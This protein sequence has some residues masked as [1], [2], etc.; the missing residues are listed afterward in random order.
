MKR[1]FISSAINLNEEKI[2]ILGW[3]HGLRDMKKIQFLVVRDHTGIVQ[4]THY[5]PNNNELAE[6]ISGVTKESAIEIIGVVKKNTGVNLHG[7]EIIP[8]KIIIHNLADPQLPINEESPQDLRLDWRFL[9]LRRPKNQLIFKAQT[10]AEEAMRE[11]WINEGLIEM[12]SP[13]LLSTASESGAELFQLEYFDKTACLA[14]SPQ[15]YKQMAMASGFN[16]VFEIGPVFRANKSRTRRHDTEFTSVDVEIPWINSYEDIMSFMER[17]L[18]HVLERINDTLGEE[19]KKLFEV[20]VNVPDSPF[21]RMTMQEAYTL[22]DELGHSTHREEKG[23]LDP[24]GEQILC[25]YMQRKTGHEFLFV[26]EYP[27][28]VRP[29]YHMRYEDRPK[30]TKSFDLLWK[31]IEVTTGAQREHR[32][33]TLLSQALEKGLT[34]ESITDY[35]NIFR[36]GCPPHGGFGFGLTRMLMMLLNLENVR[37]ATYL[38]RG[39][40]RLTP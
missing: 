6:A 7:V 26:T 37:E 20:N 31:G 27:T 36:F 10:V 25:E 17:W 24:K 12:H 21:P 15:F 40:N 14:Q 2:R 3:V 22:L 29:F 4:I 8:E 23:D 19:I 13:K 16:G 30:I 39:V 32:H 1:T 18:K 33:D 11:F 35:L 34:A 28:N 5:K 9:D 38:Y